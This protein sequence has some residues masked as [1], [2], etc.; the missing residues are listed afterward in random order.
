MTD[1]GEIVREYIIENFLFGDDAE[2]EQDSSFIENG[3][4]DSTGIIELV[5]FVEKAFEIRV[6]DE[7]LVPENFDS[8]YKLVKYLES[9]CSGN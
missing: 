2:L 7:E 9:K 6:D 4:L 5:A 8:I 1:Y 3:I